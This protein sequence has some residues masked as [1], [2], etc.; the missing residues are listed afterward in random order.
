MFHLGM[1]TN[2]NFKWSFRPVA[3]WMHLMGVNL[4]QLTGWRFWNFLHGVFIL[5]FTM[6]CRCFDLHVSEIFSAFR[7]ESGSNYETWNTVIDDIKDILEAVGIHLTM[8]VI[9]LWKWRNLWD[10]LLQIE[11]H[12]TLGNDFY[13]LLRKG[14]V[15]AVVCLLLVTRPIVLN[16]SA[17]HFLC[18]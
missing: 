17:V 16:Q 11:R 9:S 13:V 14:S 8:L 10:I 18:N 7:I 4:H 1:D 2:L 6:G 12:V 15:A 5:L 3:V